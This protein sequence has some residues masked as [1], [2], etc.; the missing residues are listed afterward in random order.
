V[1][2]I[3]LPAYNEARNLDREVVRLHAACER[4]GLAYEVVIVDD[5]STDDTPARVEALAARY[6]VRCLSHATNRGLGAA[7][8]TGLGDLVERAAP[9]DCIV[10]KDADNSQ[11][12]ELVVRM[13]GEIAR[14]QDLVIASRY[15]PG[16]AEIGLP[17]YRR[18]L[19][20][21]AGAIF[22]CLCP[23]PGVRDFTCGYRAF[24]AS[25]LQRA[26]RLHEPTGGLIEASGFACTPELLLKVARVTDRITEVPLVLRYDLKA[27]KSK[28][29]VWRTVRGNLGIVL[30]VRRLRVEGA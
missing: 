16:G 9:G 17:L 2:R 5:G 15:Q 13:A 27:G 20:R 25:T 30:R 22:Q 4:R 24:R 29:R 19:S 1:L 11:D 3:L 26:W 12:P 14:G 8:R 21:G 28:M 18:L 23:V 7:M 10:T 6:P